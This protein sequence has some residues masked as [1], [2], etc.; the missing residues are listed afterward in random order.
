M[1]KYL[2]L[3]PG[4]YLPEERRA[5][6]ALQAQINKDLG[7]RDLSFEEIRNTAGGQS[8]GVPSLV[9]AD[10]EAIRAQMEKLDPMNPIWF[11]EDLRVTVQQIGVC[12]SGLFE[13]QDDMSTVSY[14]YQ[15]EPHASFP[16]FPTAKERHPR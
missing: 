2:T 10:S 4:Q 1:N 11:S 16:V 5:M 15:T 6:E 8:R 7:R 12:H 14:W 3:Y 13:R 9:T